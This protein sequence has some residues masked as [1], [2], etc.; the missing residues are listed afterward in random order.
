MNKFGSTPTSVIDRA[1]K[2]LDRLGPVFSDFERWDDWSKRLNEI[3][4]DAPKRP[5]VAI[6]LV[7]GTGAGKSTLVNALLEARVLPVGNMKACTA[8][9]SEVSYDEGPDYSAEV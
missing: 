2:F 6:S 3:I 5:E 7:G 1:R 8:A 9:I 4:R